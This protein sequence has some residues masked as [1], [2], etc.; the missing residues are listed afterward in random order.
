MKPLFY[1]F[2]FLTFTVC[3]TPC[4]IFTYNFPRTSDQ[5]HFPR[6]YFPASSIP[7]PI[8]SK[9]NSTIPSLNQFL[10]K[11]HTLAF[12][13]I[14]NDTIQ[15]EYYAPHVTTEQTL[16]LFSISKSV[17]AA[18]LAIA[19]KE[20][21]ISDISDKLTYYIPD[22]PPA[23]Q[24]ISLVNLLN[25]R[26]GIEA[27]WYTSTVLYHSSHLDKT[28]RNIPLL[29]FPD[30]R[31][32]YCNAATQWLIPLI[33]KTT[34]QKFTDYFYQ[35]LWQPLG[36]EYPGNWSI[37]SPKYQTARGFCGLSTSL[38]D[39]AKIGLCFLHEGYY[40]GKEILPPAWIDKTFTL[41][42]ASEQSGEESVYNMHWRILTPNE[43]F[44]AKGLL[45]QYLYLNKKDNDLIIR[46]GSKESSVDWIPFFR[47]LISGGSFFH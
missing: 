15:A 5:Q 9:H 21:Y 38:R 29:T 32:E 14:H 13:W 47:Q 30:T 22:I 35:K 46:L 34:G 28:L 19:W 6:I 42:P 16:D 24:E 12:L 26:C 20:G 41:P 3:C 11:H 44:L 36:M 2:I 31:Y 33:E 7:H 39:L 45:G 25:M 23:Y 8:P 17:V 37:D 43:E 1:I 4:R 40:G 10:Q 18:V 27:S